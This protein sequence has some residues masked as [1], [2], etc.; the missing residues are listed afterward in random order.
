[1][2]PDLPLLPGFPAPYLH[3]SFQWS[4]STSVWMDSGHTFVHVHELRRK[5]YFS[6]C[7]T[8]KAT[9][10]STLTPLNSVIE[11]RQTPLV[12]QL[13]IISLASLPRGITLLVATLCCSWLLTILSAQFNSFPQPRKDLAGNLR[14]DTHR[15]WGRHFIII[16]AQPTTSWKQTNKQTNKNAE[17]THHVR[18]TT[19]WLLG[20]YQCS[21]WK[22]SSLFF[23]AS[24]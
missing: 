15:G 11:F 6:V 20:T 8:P 16:Q 5:K 13:P 2:T 23:V 22:W 18:F 14:A 17:S 9:F 21:R 1:M 19:D 4:L 7:V 3:L 10:H 24:S 12:M